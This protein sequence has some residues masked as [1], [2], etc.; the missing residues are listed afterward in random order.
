VN[1]IP[2]PDDHPEDMKW[3]WHGAGM[4]KEQTGIF[5]VP[6]NARKVL[7][8]DIITKT[9]SLIEIEYDKDI[10]VD[11][12]LDCTNKWYGGITG[13][14]NGKFCFLTSYTCCWYCFV[15]HSSSSLFLHSA[16]Y[17]VPYRA[18]GVLRIDTTTDTA[19]IIGPNYG[20]GNYYWHGGE[21]RCTMRQ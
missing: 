19:K 21:F 4:N 18:P 20:I 2:L 10:Y 5:C 9:T 15:E 14:D 1:L 6:S 7:K 17:C 16:V 8:I 11:F 3:Q 13:D 12:S